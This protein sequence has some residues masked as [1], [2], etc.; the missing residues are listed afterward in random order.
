MIIAIFIAS[1]VAVSIGG[2]IY[3]MT[4]QYS[5][6][7]AR[8]TMAAELSKATNRLDNDIKFATG[9]LSISP[10]D[11]SG[12]QNNAGKWATNTS[13]NLDTVV[14]ATM[15]RD[16]N[17]NSINNTHPGYADSIIYY[18]RDGNLFRRIVAANQT[19]NRYT[20]LTCTLTPTGGCPTDE[21]VLENLKSFN[22]TLYT[23][24]ETATSNPQLAKSIKLEIKLEVQKS[25][26]ALT[27]SSTLSSRFQGA[28]IIAP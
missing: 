5:V 11:P 7:V 21:K 12:P 8:N 9:A 28:E 10:I 17:G 15:A 18:V 19:G 4:K 22:V 3:T 1:L 23:E 16:V 6:S 24:N 2:F 27:Q 14:L 25:G 20:T 13:S 26:Q